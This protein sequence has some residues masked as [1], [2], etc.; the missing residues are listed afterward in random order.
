MNEIPVYREMLIN[1]DNDGILK[2]LLAQRKNFNT[3]WG[4]EYI[5]MNEESFIKNNSDQIIEVMVK[6]RFISG[7]F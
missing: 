1:S 4:P 6:S 2:E 3:Y 7:L 5:I